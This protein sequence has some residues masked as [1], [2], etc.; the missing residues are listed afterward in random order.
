MDL[1]YT[2]GHAHN[3][4]W[5]RPPHINPAHHP[6]WISPSSPLATPTPIG[7]RPSSGPAP[8]W[9]GRGLRE[10][11]RGLSGWAWPPLPLRSPVETPGAALGEYRG[12]GIPGQGGPTGNIEPSLPGQPARH[13]GSRWKRQPGPFGCQAWRGGPGPSGAWLVLGLVFRFFF[14]I[15]IF[16]FFPRFFVVLKRIPGGRQ[17][18]A[19]MWFFNK[20]E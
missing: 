3:S 20:W 12:R 19:G 1:G 13:C 6:H 4:H 5:L 18:A 8:E 9:C 14:F 17:R 7:S 11:G 16:I 2:R 15:I 10:R